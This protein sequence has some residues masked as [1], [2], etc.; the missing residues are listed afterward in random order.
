MHYIEYNIQNGIMAQ[1]YWEGL[2]WKG[3]L[4][5]GL[6]TYFLPMK[7]AGR[8]DWAGEMDSF[9]CCHGTMVQ[10]NAAWNRGIYYQEE[11]S[12]YITRYIDADV[13]F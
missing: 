2:S 3:S 10:A 11:Q 8:K 9:F 6:L 13:A 7:A 1:S 12:I 4:G 5:R